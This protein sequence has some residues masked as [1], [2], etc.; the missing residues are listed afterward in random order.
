MKKAIKDI[1]AQIDTYRALG[2]LP[3]NVLNHKN[4]RAEQI[5]LSLLIFTAGFFFGR[6]KKS[7]TKKASDGGTIFSKVPCILP[8]DTCKIAA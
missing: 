2:W 8:T 4:S 6:S 3:V 1:V 5:L 7:W